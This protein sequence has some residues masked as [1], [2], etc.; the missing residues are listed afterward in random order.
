MPRT[1]TGPGALAAVLL[2]AGT[3]GCAVTSGTE[4]D[5]VVPSAATSSP[6][7]SQA[8]AQA[9]TASPSPTAAEPSPASTPE[10][11]A[12]LSD[13]DTIVQALNEARAPRGHRR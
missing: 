10:T 7:A 3:A 4:P 8:E 12:P 6:H 13:V 11:A 1:R 5:T 9:E 2:A